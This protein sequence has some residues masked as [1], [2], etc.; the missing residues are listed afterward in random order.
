MIHEANMDRMVHIIK[1]HPGLVHQKNDYSRTPLMYAAE[2]GKL[3]IVKLLIKNH[4]DVNAL[5]C[6]QNT[7]LHCAAEG[8][9]VPTIQH[10]YNLD[11]SVLYDKNYYLNNACSEKTISLEQIDYLCL[12]FFHSFI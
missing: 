10:V 7:L 11:P 4:A 5:D 2:Q 8:G 3:D 6:H 12:L 9:D 1:H